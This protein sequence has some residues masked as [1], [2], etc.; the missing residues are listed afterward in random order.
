MFDAITSSHIP[1]W[2]KMCDGMCSAC[3]AQRLERFDEHAFLARRRFRRPDGGRRRELLHRA[4]R[5]R[6][7]LLGPERMI[8]AHRLAP[9]REGEVGIR[10][11]SLLKRFSRDLEFEVEESLDAREKRRLRGGFRRRRKM[12]RAKLGRGSLAANRRYQNRRKDTHQQTTP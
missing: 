7:I 6:E 10:F 1:S 2:T 8:E 11:L 3:A 9:I 4:A 12:N 5:R